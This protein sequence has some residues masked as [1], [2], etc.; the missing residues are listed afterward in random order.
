MKSD[1]VDFETV[2]EIAPGYFMK[3]DIEHSFNFG[4]ILVLFDKRNWNRYS[5][6]QLGGEV[7]G[8]E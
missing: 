7:I 5:P 8:L 4:T 1:T 6:E 3:H 2:E